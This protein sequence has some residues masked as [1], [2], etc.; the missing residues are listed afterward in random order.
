MSFAYYNLGEISVRV[1]IE[2]VKLAITHQKKSSAVCNLV[3]MT[4]SV[5]TIDTNIS[6]CIAQLEAGLALQ[7]AKE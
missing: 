7:A 2:G 5:K 6:N 1:S 4:D 3:G